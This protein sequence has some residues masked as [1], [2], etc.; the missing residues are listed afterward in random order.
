VGVSAIVTT[1]V[2]PSRADHAYA[3][4]DLSGTLVPIVTYRYEADNKPVAATLTLATLMARLSRHDVRAA[5][6]GPAWSPVTYKPGATR[7]KANVELVHALVLDVDH[8]DLPYDHLAGLVWI[9][10]TTHSHTPPDV[11]RWRVAAITSMSATVKPHSAVH[12]SAFSGSGT[13][14]PSKP[15]DH[16]PATDFRGIKSQ[17]TYRYCGIDLGQDPANVRFMS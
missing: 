4:I 2:E 14:S 6:D 9:A 10:H 1:S 13:R 16:A 3:P 11:P 12:S 7:G 5:K 15:P 17:Q 8:V